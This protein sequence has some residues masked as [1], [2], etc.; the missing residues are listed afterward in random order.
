M[1]EGERLVK[2]QGITRRGFLKYASASVGIAAGTL[3]LANSASLARLGTKESAPTE[4]VHSGHPLGVASTSQ[5]VGGRTPM[6]FLTDFYTV[7]RDPITGERVFNLEA[8]PQPITVA[9]DVQFPAWTFSAPQ[10]APM[11]PGPTLRCSAGD[12]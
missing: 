6:D 9:Q 11:V 5:T 10:R 4:Y 1:T 12:K 2:K 8:S 7:P 3:A